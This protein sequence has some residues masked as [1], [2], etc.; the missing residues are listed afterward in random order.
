MTRE[1]RTTEEGNK[2][3]PQLPIQLHF[4]LTAW[5]ATASLQHFLA[6]WMMRTIEDY[7][8]LPAGLLNRRYGDADAVFWP[9]ESVELSTAPLDTEDLFGLW[10][11]LG[12]DVYELS[13]P[14]QARGIRIEST[15]LVDEHDPVQERVQRYRKSE[16]TRAGSR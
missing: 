5:A 4:L 9:D 14:Y 12:P 15:R 8:V 3:R 13:V 11:Q 10:D 7:P 16:T 2:Q 1:G 6:G